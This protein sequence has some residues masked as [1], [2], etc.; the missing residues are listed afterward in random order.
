MNKNIA[1]MIT[2]MRH[3]LNEVTNKLAESG[4]PVEIQESSAQL[5]TALKSLMDHYAEG[6]IKMTSVIAE[7]GQPEK[8][9]RTQVEQL[10][11]E[12][13]DNIKSFR[14]K[15]NPRLVNKGVGQ[16]PPNVGQ[17]I[18]A[19]IDYTEES[20]LKNIQY[21][22]IKSELDAAAVKVTNQLEAIAKSGD[23]YTKLEESKVLLTEYKNLREQAAALH[24]KML[25][26]QS[27]Q[28]LTGQ[29]LQLL[30]WLVNSVENNLK[31]IAEEN[32]LKMPEQKEGPTEVRFD[33]Q[34]AIDDLLG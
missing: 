1:E 16:L 24:L 6:I 17:I 30:I 2:S 29:A 12:L 25:E 11:E 7:P 28:D 15:L 32:K 3:T 23:A 18:R 31:R 34:S 27:F 10:A 8:T 33:S 19:V 20:T 22:G 26:N 9:L 5:L 14:T 13:G 21:L 4:Q